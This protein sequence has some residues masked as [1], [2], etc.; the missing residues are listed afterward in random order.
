PGMMGG[1]GGMG[2]G[3]MGGQ[4]GMGPGMM[5]DQGLLLLLDEQQQ[6]DMLDIRKKYRDTQIERMSKMMDMRDEMMLLMNQPTPDPDAVKSLH[7]RMAELHGDMMADRIRMQNEIHGLLTEEQRQ[8]LQQ[9]MSQ[10]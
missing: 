9:G 5:G 3:M 8:Q 10:P 2:P 4:G 7:V 1:Q 6:R